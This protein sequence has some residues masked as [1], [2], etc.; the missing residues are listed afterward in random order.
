VFLSY[1]IHHITSF[2]H[3]QT[4][5]GSL[6]WNIIKNHHL[7]SIYVFPHLKIH[8]LSYSTRLVTLVRAANNLVHY[9][10]LRELFLRA[11]KAQLHQFARRTYVFAPQTR[12]YL[13]TKLCHV[14][15]SPR[16][17][18]FAPRIANY[19]SSL[20]VFLLRVSHLLTQITT[21]TSKLHYFH[22]FPT[23]NMYISILW[24]HYKSLT[25]II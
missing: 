22:V 7:D 17:V 23:Y 11:A 24:V 18:P 19:R 5:K 20:G 15:F 9:S 16:T 10:S 12:R 21:P 25:Y 3:Q 14:Q 13:D 6:H 1:I 2:N 4:L 8:N